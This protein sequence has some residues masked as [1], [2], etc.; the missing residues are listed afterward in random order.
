MKYQILFILSLI[1]LV[2]SV[3]LAI[4]ET[5]GGLCSV[6]GQS[7]CSLVNNSPY[8]T[9]FWGINNIYFGVVGFLALTLLIFSYLRKKTVL[10]KSIIHLGIFLAGIAGIYFI[11]LQ[12]FIL[13]TY[14]PYCMA[15]DTSALVSL[16]I[17]FFWKRKKEKI[18]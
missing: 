6:D 17:I 11:Y 16:L 2:S 8:S 1:A 3:A 5:S 14:C 7:D 12:I 9:M 4:N 13:K 18:I 10:K 15:V